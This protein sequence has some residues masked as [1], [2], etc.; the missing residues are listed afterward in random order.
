MHKTKGGDNVKK[1]VS[2]LTVTVLM[3]GMMSVTAS[4]HGHGRGN[5]T[6]HEAGYSSCTVEDGAQLG[7][8][9]HDGAYY[10]CANHTLH[11]GVEGYCG[12]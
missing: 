6:R 1:A 11:H 4:A 8:H 9:E 5:A 7:L 12:W 2:I 3:A 10:Y